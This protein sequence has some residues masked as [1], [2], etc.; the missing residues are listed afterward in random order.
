MWSHVVFEHPATFDTLAMVKTKKKK[1]MN[2]LITFTTS[3]DYYKKK[4]ERPGKEV[5]FLLVPIQRCKRLSVP[6][7]SDG[8]KGFLLTTH[9]KPFF[10]FPS[11]NAAQIPNNP[12]LKSKIPSSHPSSDPIQ[13][14]MTS[15]GSTPV[16]TIREI[17][18]NISLKGDAEHTIISSKDEHKAAK[19]DHLSAKKAVSSE[20]DLRGGTFADE[21][22]RNIRATKLMA[23]RRSKRRLR[24]RCET[25]LLK[26]SLLR[27]SKRSWRILS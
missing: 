22:E 12:F 6:I 3:K 11:I 14:Q 16:P 24:T 21:E 20:L 25:L 10:F 13:I 18:G 19:R 5:I 17:T 1:I 8:V 9:P 27:R 15:T 2:D 23:L 4:L 7:Q 26:L